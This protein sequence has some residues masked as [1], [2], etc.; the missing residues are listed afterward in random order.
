MKQPA[1]STVHIS[2]LGARLVPAARITG[3]AL[4]L[5]LCIMFGLVA[6]CTSNTKDGKGGAGDGGQTKGKTGSETGGGSGDKK[7]YTQRIL[8]LDP[9]KQKEYGVVVP[10]GA[11]ALYNPRSVEDFVQSLTLFKNTNCDVIDTNSDFGKDF[12]KVNKSNG[13]EYRYQ[14]WYRGGMFVKKECWEV[15]Y[16]P[17]QVKAVTWTEPSISGGVQNI[18]RDHWTVECAN[19]TVLVRGFNS[20]APEA[21]RAK[22]DELQLDVV[23]FNTTFESICPRKSDNGI[24]NGRFGGYSGR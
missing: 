5:L 6:G 23:Y 18:E 4:G 7:S 11:K 16:G 2:T 13:V 10:K 20:K 21:S 12:R 3:P 24:R 15:I 1:V 9:A 22:K 8:D 14:A 17:R 19:E